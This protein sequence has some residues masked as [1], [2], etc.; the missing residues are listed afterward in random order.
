VPFD[1]EKTARGLCE[2][3]VAEL[4]D[5]TFVMVSRGSN[6]V[7]I[8]GKGQVVKTEHPGVKWVSYS[9]DRGQSWTKAVPLT[10][11][12]GKYLESSATGS[13]LFRSIVNGKLYWLGNLC[14][15][16]QKAIGNWPR[17]HLMLAELS[18]SGCIAVKRETIALVAAPASGE[19]DQVQHSNFRAYQDRETGELV[20]LMNRFFERGGYENMAWHNTDLYRYRIRIG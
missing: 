1:T 17:D 13:F 15:E 16:S 18:E 3:T 14:T 6:A 19:T 10:D 20:L 4:L 8:E 5:G 9:Y 12:Y 11:E 7:F 2:P